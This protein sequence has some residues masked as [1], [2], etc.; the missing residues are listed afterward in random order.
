MRI[1]NPESGFLAYQKIL[2]HLQANQVSVIVW[3]VTSEGR[4]IV[5]SRLHSF[6]MDSKLMYMELNELM[7]FQSNLPVYCYAEDGL[8][9]FKTQ[10]QEMRHNNLS[11]HIPEEI[12]LLEDPEINFIAGQVGPSLSDVWRI[13]RFNLGA[14][15]IDIKAKAMSERSHRDQDF[16]NHEF[17]EMSLDEE[18]KLFANK[19]ESPRGRPKTDK[20]V[21]V[22]LPEGDLYEGKLFDLSRGGMGF[23]SHDNELFPKGAEIHILGFDDFNLDDPLIGKIMSHR[24]IDGTSDWK[25]GVKFD[26]GQA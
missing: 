17:D 5:Q 7:T 22:K 13:K 14:T 18:D 3:Q 16:L 10:I 6:H 8:L 15:D 19:R 25:V 11:L 20:K 4:K 23:V 12:T 9:I 26:D 21:R 1:V 24:T 2:R